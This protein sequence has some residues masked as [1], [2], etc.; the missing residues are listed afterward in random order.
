M[1]ERSHGAVL[2]AST[3]L[4]LE[5]IREQLHLKK[6]VVTRQAVQQWCAGT[7]KP[8]PPARRML[9]K[10]Y[11]ID[12]DTWDEDPPAP[13]LAPEIV[14]STASVNVFDLASRMLRTLERDVTRIESDAKLTNV[15]RAK[16][17]SEC[18]KQIAQFGE[19]QDA[20]G[21]KLLQHPQWPKIRNTL[22]NA[23]RPFGADALKAVETAFEIIETEIGH[24]HD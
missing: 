6:L 10:L 12:E 13:V 23:V 2:L 24:P 1:T 5:E 20:G 19:M 11:A 18:L 22:V 3:G 17:R 15:E 4:S 21:V 9:K 16:L 14:T 8:K 7:T